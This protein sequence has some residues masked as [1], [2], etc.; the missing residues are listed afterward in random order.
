[1]GPLVFLLAK[2]N[3]LRTPQTFLNTPAESKVHLWKLTKGT[4]N[5][6]LDV[7]YKQDHRVNYNLGTPYLRQQYVRFLT[8]CSPSVFLGA[9]NEPKARPTLFGGSFRQIK[10]H[11]RP[12]VAV[13]DFSK[14]P[15]YTARFTRLKHFH[16]FLFL[17]FTVNRYFLTKTARFGLSL[18]LGR[19]VS[20]L[21]QFHLYSTKLLTYDY[22]G[23]RWGV[24]TYSPG[25]VL[26]YYRAVASYAL[27]GQRMARFYA[28]SLLDFLNEE[29]F[30]TL[31]EETF[32]GIN[33]GVEPRME[34]EPTATEFSGV[35]TFYLRNE[36]FN[37]GRYARNR[38]TYRT[39]VLWCV[40]LTVFTIVLPSYLWY[41]ITV[42]VSY[43]YPAFIGTLAGVS[44][45]YFWRLRRWSTHRTAAAV[46]SL[47]K[48]FNQ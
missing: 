13:R 17:Y 8:A 4:V 25:S 39:G 36:A 16:R 42:K 45:L 28:D 7:L 9:L 38:Q 12:L 19:P 31:Y 27:K 29:E 47:V 21:L 15:S 3:Q 23:L 20:L 33:Q 14:L 40:W 43:L 10:R 18:R 44:G 37:K 6:S 34:R 24:Y 48:W 1:M 41:G 22:S 32:F 35:P 11:L 46:E 2:Y 26:G 30:E 5:F